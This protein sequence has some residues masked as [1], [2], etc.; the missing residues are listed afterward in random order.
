VDVDEKAVLIG[1]VRRDFNAFDDSVVSGMD[2]ITDTT[3]IHA[4]ILKTPRAE[5]TETLVL[6]APSHSNA[7]GLAL[8]SQLLA[9]YSRFSYWSVDI[10]FIVVHD[11]SA[12]PLWLETHAVG[13][14]I[15]ALFNFEF[16]GNQSYRA[17]GIAPHGVNGRLPN[18]D[19]VVSV[20]KSFEFENC[21]VELHNHYGL[22]PNKQSW[23]EQMPF[24]FDFVNL[25]LVQFAWTQALGF[26]V[27]LHSLLT[28]YK[29][30]A[31]TI[32]GIPA[33]EG[34]HKLHWTQIGRGIEGACRGINNVTFVI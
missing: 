31:I 34:D 5:G 14:N 6:M 2:L 32:T 29:V 23:K 16:P 15:R 10:V 20:V 1:Q 4:Q 25:D 33:S 21:P 24:I 27:G 12:L 7:D 22:F 3:E 17:I 11:P 26:P 18:A 9:Y 30:E 8:L 19:L 13:L 28:N